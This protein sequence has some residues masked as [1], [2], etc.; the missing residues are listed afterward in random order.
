MFLSVYNNIVI[1]KSDVFQIV[2]NIHLPNL[3]P[4]A[5]HERKTMWAFTFNLCNTIVLYSLEAKTAVTLKQVD[6]EES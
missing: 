1:H 4:L 6:G 2:I 5:Q 3:Y